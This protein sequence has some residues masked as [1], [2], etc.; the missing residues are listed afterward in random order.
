MKT[1]EDFKGTREQ[2]KVGEN[3][4]AV[5]RYI[6]LRATSDAFSK[7]LVYSPND[8]DKSN[9]KLFANSYKLL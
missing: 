7:A 8:E 6:N 1:L 9:F 4:D 3:C 2:I 5:G